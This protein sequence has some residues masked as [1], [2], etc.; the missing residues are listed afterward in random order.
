M[1]D[2]V[3]AEHMKQDAEFQHDMNI[4]KN[5]VATKADIERIVVEAIEGYF[6]QKSKSAYTGLLI[7]AGIFGALAIIGGGF[8]AFLAWLGF[9]YISK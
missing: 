8:K 6:K 7:I 4:W 3:L 5:T 1:E 9:N 2:H